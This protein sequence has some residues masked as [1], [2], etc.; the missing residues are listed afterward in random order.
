MWAFFSGYLALVCINWYSEPLILLV[1]APPTMLFSNTSC[2]ISSPPPPLHHQPDTLCFVH[3]S[4]LVSIVKF[5]QEF[6]SAKGDISP[7]CCQASIFWGCL[8][9]FSCCVWSFKFAVWGDIESSVWKRW[10]LAASLGDIKYIFALGTHYQFGILL[11]QYNLERGT[12]SPCNWSDLLLQ[13]HQLF[14]RHQWTS[15]RPQNKLIHH[16]WQH[17]LPANSSFPRIVAAKVIFHTGDN[18]IGL[19]NIDINSAGQHCLIKRRHPLCF[20]S[21]TQLVIVTA[22]GFE[23]CFGRYQDLHLL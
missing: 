2:E 10:L 6:T 14:W 1:F 16:W 23:F 20:G 17:I 7:W 21:H 18:S 19:V 11:Q 13:Q 9:I 4:K 3:I 22:I 12:T 5:C 15:S 8:A